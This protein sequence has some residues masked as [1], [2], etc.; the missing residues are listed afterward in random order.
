MFITKSDPIVNKNGKV[1]D[2]V[3][4]ENGILFIED[5]QKLKYENNKW[6][7]FGD[8]KWYYIG[9]GSNPSYKTDK[10]NV[11]NEELFNNIFEE[12]KE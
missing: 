12:I 4:V 7:L 10:I 2:K 6:Y 11:L 9:V 3:K 5:T 1:T 8:N